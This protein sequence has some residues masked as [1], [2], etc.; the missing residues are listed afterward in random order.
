MEEIIL[1]YPKTS[2]ITIN[3]PILDQKEN[4]RHIFTEE[5]SKILE[6]IKINP[7]IRN[8]HEQKLEFRKYPKQIDITCP[9][10]KKNN[11]ILSPKAIEKCN[12]VYHYMIYQVPCILEGDTGTSK[13]FTASMMAQYRQ[14]EIIE[15]EKKKRKKQ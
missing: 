15:E 13:T 4:K 7:F 1:N 3:R 14:W 5:Q 8:F 9:L 6:S 2:I 11:F 10:F 12:K